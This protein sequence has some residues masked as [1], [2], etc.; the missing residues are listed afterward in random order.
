MQDSAIL[1]ILSSKFLSFLYL[2]KIRPY[3]AE[4]SLKMSAADYYRSIAV[5]ELSDEAFYEYERRSALAEEKAEDFDG[6]FVTAAAVVIRDQEDYL[7]YLLKNLL[8][9]LGV[10]SL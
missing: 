4:S 9:D 10:D 8:E 6:E 7:A 3:S 2:S 5:K 1:A